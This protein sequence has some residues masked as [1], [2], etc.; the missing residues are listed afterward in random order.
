M[1]HEREMMMT[2]SMVRKSKMEKTNEKGGKKGGV[3]RAKKCNKSIVVLNGV[4]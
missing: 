2:L 3:K 1:I 4:Q